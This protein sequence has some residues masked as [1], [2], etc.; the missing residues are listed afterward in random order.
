MKVVGAPIYDSACIQKRGYALNLN[1]LLTAFWSLSASISQTEASFDPH[2]T[3]F[4]P[5]SDSTIGLNLSEDR[6][7]LTLRSELGNVP[8]PGE[9]A[10]R[11]TSDSIGALSIRLI[12]W[13]SADQTFTYRFELEEAMGGSFTRYTLTNQRLRTEDGRVWSQRAHCFA[14]KPAIPLSSLE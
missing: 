10:A 1:I 12:R 13:A 6:A 7:Q 5:W 14:V 11:V 8:A 3:L 2:I 4:C 9:Y